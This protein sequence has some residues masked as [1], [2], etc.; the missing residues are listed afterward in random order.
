MSANQ[1]RPNNGG[2][3]AI[4]ARPYFNLIAPPANAGKTK[5]LVDLRK[6]LTTAIAPRRVFC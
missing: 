4:V 1:S 5:K 2:Q 3:P 6:S